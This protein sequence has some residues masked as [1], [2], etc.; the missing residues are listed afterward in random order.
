ML[1]AL[2]SM[3]R[4]KPVARCILEVE[5]KFQ[6]LAVRELTTANGDPPFHRI[7]SLGQHTFRDIY[8]DR[9][10]LLSSAGVWVRQRNGAWQGKVKRGGNFTNSRFEELSHPHQI[11]ECLK[12]ITG[13]VSTEQDLFGLKRIA[14]LSTTRKAWRADDEFTIVLD[15]TDFGHTVGEVELQQEL[16][17]EET[18]GAC[19]EEQKQRIMQEMDERIAG[20][21]EHY[22]WAFLSGLPIG[23]LTA[24]FAHRG[25]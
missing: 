10:G 18:R 5:R 21:M 1:I 4:C 11:S 25:I 14:A 3:N 7:Q 12:D 16:S 13:V 8:Y 6:S 17:L 15:T 20:F 2:P 24:Y 9:A 19:I 22:S 23:K